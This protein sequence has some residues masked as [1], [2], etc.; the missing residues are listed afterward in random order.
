MPADE[1]EEVRLGHDLAAS[2]ALDAAGEFP[3]ED[4]AEALEARG[5][6]R[7][8]FRSAE[9]ADFGGGAFAEVG[10]VGI[11]GMDEVLKEVGAGELG[12]RGVLDCEEGLDPGFEGGEEA[13][14]GVTGFFAGEGAF[15]AGAVVDGFAFAEFH[16][17]GGGEE[18]GEEFEVI[19][20]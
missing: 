19:N 20:G 10:M 17:F 16:F 1:D 18:A 3:A 2:E 6:I 14:D 11:L 12:L 9:V 4:A 13:F 7:G 5:A 8:D 15:E